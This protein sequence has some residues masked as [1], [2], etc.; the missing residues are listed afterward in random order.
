[1]DA[2]KITL[3]QTSL[4][5]EDPQKNREH[6]GKLLKKIRKG[7]TDIIVLPEM[8]TTGFTMNARN[9]AE[10]MNGSTVTWMKEQAMEK[11]AVVC[12]S[13]I[14]TE[15]GKYFNRLVWVQPDGKTFHYD[16]RHLFR[17]A[18]E[19]KTYSQGNKKLVVKFRGWNICPL[20]CYD[21]RF[22]VWSR[23]DGKTDL[24]IFV[25]NWPEK[26]SYAWKQLL[27]ARAIENQ[28][29]VAGLNRVGNDGKDIPYS[30]D[31]VVL[32]PLGL[33]ISSGGN[34]QKIFTITIRKTSLL[35]FRKAFPVD[36]DRDNFRI[37]K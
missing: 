21:L 16:K 26:R 33:P 5:W 28:A 18:S 25:A 31:S 9:L 19:H 1:M 35:A 37:V 30:G 22:P 24:M 4:V 3:L 32:D 17:M 13:L 27:I 12:G 36:L 6:F 15:K 29:Y 23:N 7:A 14:I 34:R 2:L 8:F 11:D 20:V 10:K